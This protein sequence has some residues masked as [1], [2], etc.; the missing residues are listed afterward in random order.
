MVMLS[1]EIEN[2]KNILREV[3]KDLS[4][5]ETDDFQANFESAKDKM[6]IFHEMKEKLIKDYSLEELRNYEQELLII[7]KQ[8]NNKYDN[9]IEVKKKQLQEVGLKI[10]LL[11]NRKKLINY[12]R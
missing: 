10:R 11:Q 3:I 8:I 2:I 9:V 1:V 12:S 4:L 6:R 5:I 7:T